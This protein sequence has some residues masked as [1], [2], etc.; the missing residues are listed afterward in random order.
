[1]FQI[2]RLA[3]RLPLVVALGGAFLAV[4]AVTVGGLAIG[5]GVSIVNAQEGEGSERQTR[6]VVAMS[7]KV[8]DRLQDVQEAVSPED[9]DGNPIEGFEPDYRRAISIL[10]EI[11]AMD[12]LNSADRTQLW[13]FYAF[14][15]VSMDDYPRAI[16]AYEQILRIEDADPRFQNSI[17]YN[18]AQLYM[19][20]EDYRKTISTLDDWFAS[21]GSE[22]IT[23]ESRVLY[24]QAYYML[25][26][27][28]TARGPIEEAIEMREDADKEPKENW[29]Q[30]I[31]HIYYELDEKEKALEVVEFLLRNWPKKVYWLQLSSMYGELEQEDLQ[32]S[33]LEAAYRNGYLT[34]SRELENLAQIYLYHGVPFKAAKVVEKGM[35]DGDIEKTEKN[36]DL[37]ARSWLNAQ[38]YEKAVDPL[39]EAASRSDD[40]ETY[41]RLARVYSQLD[42]NEKV[43]EAGRLALREGGIDR[44]DDVY[45]LIGMAQFDLDN[46]EDAKKSFQEAAK[47]SNSRQVAQNWIKYIDNEIARRESIRKFMEELEQERDPSDLI[48][49]D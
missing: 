43:I 1:M 39:R 15:Y 30:L 2:K 35:N 48:N 11:R 7:S 31:R 32:V 20:T 36:W 21:V 19:A 23:A 38:E 5:P 9:E 14:V 40:G 3:L 4:P 34:Q 13:N 27:F 41:V 44:P 6:R 17:R 33:A 12:N 47:S 8:L 16:E 29:Y 49:L 18:L 22:G 24:G 28:R 37:L 45:V 46:L 10:N 26:D 42:N 25:D